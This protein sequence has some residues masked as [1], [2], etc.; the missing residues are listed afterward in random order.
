MLPCVKYWW[1]P[2]LWVMVSVLKSVSETGLLVPRASPFPTVC[3]QQLLKACRA[4][5]HLING[6]NVSPHKISLHVP[7]SPLVMGAVIYRLVQGA[8]S[9][10]ARW[11]CSMSIVRKCCVWLCLM[12]ENPGC[13]IEGCPLSLSSLSL[14]LLASAHHL[15][16]LTLLL[17]IES[18][19][20]N[21]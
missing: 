20:A 3:V 15:L 17:F 11:A 12:G 7:Y 16:Q 10:T 14:V 21:S 2:V 19:P 4:K 18:L 5:M 8:I 9:Q 1:Y 6:R 13:K